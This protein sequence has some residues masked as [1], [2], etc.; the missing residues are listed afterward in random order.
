MVRLCIL[1][2]VGHILRLTHQ[3]HYRSVLKFKLDDFKLSSY[4]RK[5]VDIDDMI[6]VKLEDYFIAYNRLASKLAHANDV[7]CRLISHYLYFAH[8][9]VVVNKI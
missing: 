1:D 5:V 6:D 4:N 8:L 3:L 7:A 2:S 9:V